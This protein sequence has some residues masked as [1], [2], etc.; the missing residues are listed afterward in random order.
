[1]GKCCGRIVLASLLIAAAGCTNDAPP[2]PAGDN[3]IT[4]ALV[5]IQNNFDDGTTQGWIPRGPVT[6]SAPS[7][8]AA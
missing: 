6:L 7:L 8:P 3:G 2:P 5:S 1:M 4:A